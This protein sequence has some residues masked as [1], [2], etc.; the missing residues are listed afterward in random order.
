MTSLPP[1]VEAYFEQQRSIQQTNNNLALIERN[2]VDTTKT[3][4]HSMVQLLDRQVD[5]DATEDASTLL[6]E[7]SKAFVT[8]TLPW[9]KRICFCSC[10]Q[11]Y[12]NGK[13]RNK[14]K[15]NRIP[16]RLFKRVTSV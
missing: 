16:T 14:T 2:L 9:Y 13:G 3:L 1:A 7:S 6:L 15:K 8:E 5:I 10:C 12:K 11:S 4:Q